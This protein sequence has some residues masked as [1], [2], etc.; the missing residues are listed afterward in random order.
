MSASRG[1]QVRRAE[2]LADLGRYDEAEQELRAALAADAADIE[3]LA[4]LAYVCLRAGRAHEALGSADA[5]ISLAPGHALAQDVRNQ[6]LVALGRADEATSAAPIWPDSQDPAGFPPETSPEQPWG[7]ARPPDS[8]PV[9]PALAEQLREHFS[10][11]VLFGSIY[12]WTAPVL[13]AVLG[14]SQLF[15]G[16]LGVGALVAL[17]LSVAQLPG[18]AGGALGAL[19]RV[20]P[21]LAR[22]VLAVAAAPVLMLVYAVTAAPWALGAV[23][24]AGVAALIIMFVV[25]ADFEDPR[26]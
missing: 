25:R 26:P 24:V 5:A 4:L 8:E 16:V 19:Q 12:C 3:A 20:D 23:I 11:T 14:K 22:A 6:A 2:L 9:D 15:A 7:P 10:R 13:V 17:L 21:W 18:S 1:E